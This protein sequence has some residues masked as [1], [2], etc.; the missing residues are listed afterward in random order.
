VILIL[1]IITTVYFLRLP[2]HKFIHGFI[3]SVSIT[4]GV[5]VLLNIRLKISVHTAGIG[6]LA[7]LIIAL[8]MLYQIPMEGILILVLLAGG[9][10]AT[11]Q[12]VL[13]AHKPYE[14]YG[15]FLTGFACV[16]ATLLVY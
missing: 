5:L 8:I 3:L 2:L 16:L 13:D 14:V 1:Y 7:G 4:L 11:S 10:V 6:G 15:G 9:G 12:L